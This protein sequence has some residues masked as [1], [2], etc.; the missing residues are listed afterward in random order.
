M[1][2]CRWSD[3]DYRCDVYVYHDVGGWWQ[4]YVAGRRHVFDPPPPLPE[5]VDMATDE[6]LGLWMERHLEVGRRV[7]RAEVVDIDLPEAGESFRHF[8][9]GESADNLERLRGLGYHVPQY[10][11]DELRDEEAEAPHA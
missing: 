9:P 11:I 6:G 4:T 10:A 5:D 1:S 7:R 8:T 2:Y 3:D